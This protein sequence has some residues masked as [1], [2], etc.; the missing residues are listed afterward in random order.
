LR[1]NRSRA[2]HLV[3]GQGMLFR[4]EVLLR[5]LD[6]YAAAVA[7]QQRSFPTMHPACN[8][9]LTMSNAIH[10]AGGGI[11]IHLPGMVR[12]SEVGQQTACGHGLVGQFGSARTWS[13]DWRRPDGK[14]RD[15]QAE[16]LWGYQTRW[17]ILSAGRGPEVVAVRT[18][19]GVNPLGERCTWNGR[20][21][22]LSPASLF[23]SEVEAQ[24]ALAARSQ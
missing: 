19:P 2:D 1:I 14:L 22:V 15:P 16:H 11:Y 21:L 12:V 24:A 5:A 3:G 4:S 9:D 7:W 10:Q 20:P 17:A 23:E 13:P 6:G 18:P 8:F